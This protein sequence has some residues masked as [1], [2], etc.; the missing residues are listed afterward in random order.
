MSS[1]F[2]GFCFDY[3]FLFLSF[4]QSAIKYFFLV[5]TSIRGWK[6]NV[7]DSL[8]EKV[9]EISE[10]SQGSIRLE[11]CFGSLL[12]LGSPFKPDGIHSYKY[13]ET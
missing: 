1:R 2:T 12:K 5:I 11:Y 13:Q 8:G 3:N 9:N 6:S 10:I 7:K 4:V